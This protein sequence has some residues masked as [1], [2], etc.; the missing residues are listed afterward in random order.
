MLKTEVIDTIAKRMDEELR[1]ECSTSRTEY[2][3]LWQKEVLEA[4]RNNLITTITSGSNRESVRTAILER[5]KEIE[6]INLKIT[7]IKHGSRVPDFD[8][9]R[10]FAK[11]RLADLRNLLGKPDNIAEFRQMLETRVGI[12]EMDRL[13]TQAL[14]AI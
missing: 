9:L 11:S 12:I 4:E 8:Q 1:H 5:E 2:K 10:S 3:Q 14:P 6:A 7:T 13:K